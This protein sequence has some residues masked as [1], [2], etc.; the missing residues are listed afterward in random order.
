MARLSKTRIKA[1]KA[2]L[3]RL[4]K[5]IRSWRKIAA[6]YYGGEVSHGLLQRFAKEP[7]YIPQDE[8][9]QK[10]LD[11]PTPKNPYRILPRWY[12]R[13]PEAL[14]FFNNKRA[15][16]KQMQNEQNQQRKALAR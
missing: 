14:A 5:L 2:E 3:R 6:E 13:T 12:K 7:D 16:I 10:A 11:L 15:Q 1:R 4:H 8:R 9:I